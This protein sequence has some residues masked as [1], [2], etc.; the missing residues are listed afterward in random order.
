[1]KRRDFLTL[2]ALG[3]AALA[4][5]SVVL[6][7][8]LVYRPGIVEQELKAGRLVLLDFY[9]PWC[10]TCRAQ[11][12]VIEALR[13]ENPEY[14]RRIAFVEVDWDSHRKAEITRK[15]KIPRRSTLVLLSPEGEVGRV[16]AETS[17]EAIKGLLDWAVEGS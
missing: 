17:R 8:E 15:L 2:G 13:A 10:G 3:A 14:D 5:P 16:V 6:G 4:L 9:A 12:R 7:D 11:R 1:M